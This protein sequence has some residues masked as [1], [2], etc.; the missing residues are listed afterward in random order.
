MD[1]TIRNLDEQVYREFRARAVRQGRNVGELLND[2]MRTY[3][4]R[5]AVSPGRSSLRALK[6]EPFPEGNELLSQEVDAIV[7]GE[8]RP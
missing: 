5:V 6:P 8:R 7:Y 3:L 2:A 1:T 4:A